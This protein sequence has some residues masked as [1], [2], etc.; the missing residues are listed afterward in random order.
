MTLPACTAIAAYKDLTHEEWLKLRMTG[1]GGSESAKCMNMSKYGSSLTMVMEKTGRMQPKDLSENDAVIVGTKLEDV[2]RREFVAEY[3]KEKLGID[4]E[5]IAP[6]HMYRSIENPFMLYN[7]DGFLNV[8]DKA[9][10]SL[11]DNGMHIEPKSR[12]VG[13]EIK[14]GNSYVLKNWGGKEGD[15]IPDDY[16]CQ[17]QH[18]MSVTGLDEFWVFGLIGNQRLL[19]IIPRNDEFI[20]E[21]IEQERAVWDAVE[22]NDPLYFPLPSGTDADMDALFELSNPQTEDVADLSDYDYKL[23]RYKEITA[24]MNTLKDEKEIIKQTILSLMGNSKY[25]ETESHRVT[26]SRYSR[27]S[28]SAKTIKAKHPRIWKKYGTESETGKMSVKEIK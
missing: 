12:L 6:T 4:V 22:R 24:E 16:Y 27:P 26:F 18:G 8:F 7:S 19:R 2:I 14:T 23:D 13:L 28:I 5:V 10:L 11:D 9:D 20:A 17:V 25:G 1:I 21:M 3:I 15:E